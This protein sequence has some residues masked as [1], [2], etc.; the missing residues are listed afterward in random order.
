MPRRKR[1]TGTLRNATADSPAAVDELFEAC[2]RELRRLAHK[3]LSNERQDHTLQT[4][5][6]QIED[7]TIAAIYVVRNP[8]KLRHL[9]G[10]VVH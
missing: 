4:T 2:Y 1:L 8:D 5:A 6:L 9:G 10:H 7:G 3:Y